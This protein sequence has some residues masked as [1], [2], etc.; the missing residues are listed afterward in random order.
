[1]F[2]FRSDNKLRYRNVCAFVS[3]SLTLLVLGTDNQNF[4]RQP[5]PT[6]SEQHRQPTHD[7]SAT[8]H[9]PR[10]QQPTINNQH[11]TADTRQLA[12]NNN[13]RQRQQTI[14]NLHPTA[15]IRQ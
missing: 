8:K 12:T 2:C 6:I 13:Q 1:M 3:I 10:Q 14:N 4:H 9:N 7:K 15:D 5:T 11:P